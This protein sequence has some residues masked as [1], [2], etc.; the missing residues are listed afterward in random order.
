MKKTMILGLTLICL[1][2]AKSQAKSMH[3]SN[4]FDSVQPAHSIV[5]IKILSGESCSKSASCNNLAQKKYKFVQ[6]KNIAGQTLPVESTLSVDNLCIDCEYVATFYLRRDRS[7]IVN[8]FPSNIIMDIKTGER[9]MVFGDINTYIPF[10]L[11]KLQYS[12]VCSSNM[13]CKDQMKYRYISEEQFMD[14]LL[15][16]R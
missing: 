13:K 6:L 11:T 5:L 7:V 3:E 15:K 1:F 9:R 16:F 4:F 2:V 14:F 12:S 10:E 8:I